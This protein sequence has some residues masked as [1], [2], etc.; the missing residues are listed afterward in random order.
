MDI[1]P[2]NVAHPD[3]L[4]DFRVRVSNNG[5]SMETV[6]VREI[7]TASELSIHDT[8]G[9]VFVNNRATID[10][11]AQQTKEITVTMRVERQ[12]STQSCDEVCNVVNVEQ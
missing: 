12:D 1:D 2:Y 11:P 6:D 5:T 10:V 7:F 3:S 9:A 8:K 4:I